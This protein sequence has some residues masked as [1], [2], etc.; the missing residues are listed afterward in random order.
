MGVVYLA[1]DTKLHRPVAL[2]VLPEEFARDPRRLQRFLREAHTA[3]VI[4]HPNV[5]VIHEIGEAADQTPFIAMEYV[6]GQTLAAKIAGRPL[7]LAELLDIAIEVAEALDEAHARGVIHR[8]LK[9]ANVIITPRG[10]AKVLDFGLAK[11]QQAT[12][13]EDSETRV[14]STPG[15]V[16]GTV[17][18]MSPEQALGHDVDPRS[19][20][21][22][23]GVLLYE[24]ATGRQAFSGRSST[25]TIEQI[26]HGQPDPIARFNY[27]VPPELER[28]IRKSLEKNPDSRYQSGRDLL[29]DLRNLRR[30]STSAERRPVEIPRRR[31][32]LPAAIAAA[33]VSIALVA[34]YVSR[35]TTTVHAP[36]DSLAVLPFINATR[37]PQSEVLAD[38]MTETIINK[39]AELPQLKVISRSTVFRF[40]GK[41]T[42]PQKVGHELKVSSVLT[43]RIMEVGNRLDIDVELVN[44]ADG[45]QLWGERYARGV[46]D[47]F[48]MQDEIAQQVSEKLRLK[49]TGGERKRMTRRYTDDPEAYSLYVQGRLY[50]NK[51]TATSIKKAI[52][53]FSAALE[54]DPNYALAYLGIAECYMGLPQ[55][56]GVPVIEAEA[57]ANQAAIRALEID[58]DLAEAR[59]TLGYIQAL[60]WQWQGA[61]ADF[62]RAIALKP[63]DATT[64][65]WYALTLGYQR[66]YAEALSEMQK[67][68]ALDPLSS[69][70]NVNTGVYLNY[71][72]RKAEAV[73]QLRRAVDLDPAL[74][75]AHMFLGRVDMDIGDYQNG[76]LEL[77]KAVELSNRSGEPLS[78]LGF[79]YAQVGRR[80]DALA[81]IG[82]LKR[83]LK[84]NETSPFRVGYVYAGLGDRTSAYRWFDEALRE[85]DSFLMGIYAYRH[86]FD[87]WRSDPHFQQ[88]LR[89]MNLSR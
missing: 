3:S 8:D 22:S 18:Y 77:Q 38:G 1:E 71:N 68:L 50:W 13:D 54:R 36:I 30:D 23:F 64:H 69:V 28:I 25:E 5:A 76:I 40:K 33:V 55:Y 10:H 83:K 73:Q 14:K 34:V 89:G 66:R 15:L 19:D 29:I 35:R 27:G 17:Q 72:D 6:E 46:A 78:R 43:G 16:V 74:P 21:F 82:E 62:K 39:L 37:D 57:K 32:W 85:H 67:A 81:I 75:Y 79:A 44:V 80:D 60:L 2:K 63:N 4:A 84:R 41:D 56:A 87:F 31:R 45:A 12:T 42:D 9:P 58:P 20:L 86:D 65:H 51:R 61:E 88:L 26:V 47:V 11:L 52:D 24:M 59:A 53:L 7:P 49:L 48:A 70:I